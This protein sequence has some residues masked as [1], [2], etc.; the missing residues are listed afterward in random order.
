MRSSFRNKSTAELIQS[1]PLNCRISGIVVRYWFVSLLVG[2]LSSVSA[3]LH[4]NETEVGSKQKNGQKDEL[5]FS[6]AQLGVHYGEGDDI[7]SDSWNQVSLSGSWRLQHWRLKAGSGWL[8]YSDGKQGITD[9]WLSAT[10]LVQRPWLSH[11]WDVRFRLKLPTAE[12]QDSLGTGSVDQGIRLQLLQQWQQGVYWSYL[13]Y[14]Q[15]G[16]SREFDLQNSWRWGAGIK[17]ADYSLFYDGSEASQ[18]GR[19]NNHA[20]TL[21]AGF[22]WLDYHWSPYGSAEAD[23]DWS[24]GL[25]VRF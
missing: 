21:M 20:I 9:S 12:A 4:A 11:W 18:P 2:L 1:A 5:Q 19:D 13:G 22:E 16:K 14:R 10:Y 17:L 23:G 15:R 25:S 24:V 8:R 7:R 3:G 6:S